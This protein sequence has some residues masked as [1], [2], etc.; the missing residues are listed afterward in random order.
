MNDEGGVSFV[1]TRSTERRRKAKATG[2]KREGK[3]KDAA[4]QSPETPRMH[5]KKEGRERKGKQKKGL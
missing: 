2:N 4:K 3:A 5:A 1:Q